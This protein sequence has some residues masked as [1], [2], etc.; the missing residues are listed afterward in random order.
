MGG[1]GFR[2]KNP[3]LGGLREVRISQCRTEKPPE[4]VF[5]FIQITLKR[6]INIY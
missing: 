6:A 1:K 3:V 5:S 2:A 4:E